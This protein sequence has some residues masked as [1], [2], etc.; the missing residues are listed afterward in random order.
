MVLFNL[1][2]LFLSVLDLHATWAFLSYGEGGYSLVA[3]HALLVAVTSLVAE[4][5]L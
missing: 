2:E 5:R 1:I 3:V 4:H